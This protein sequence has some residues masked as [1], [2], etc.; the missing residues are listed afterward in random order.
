MVH[1][2]PICYNFHISFEKRSKNGGPTPTRRI[3]EGINNTFNMDNSCVLFF[4]FFY[5]F[6]DD[7]DEESDDGVFDSTTRIPPSSFARESRTETNPFIMTDDIR[8][9]H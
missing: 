8:C 5:L 7:D 3:F 2:A 6:E 4:S 9:A 1:M